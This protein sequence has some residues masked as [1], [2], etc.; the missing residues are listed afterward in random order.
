MSD[1]RPDRRLRDSADIV[2]SASVQAESLHFTAVPWSEVTFH[3]EPGEESASG[4]RREGLPDHVTEGET[5]RAIRIDYA[6]ASKLTSAREPG[7]RRHDG[8]GN[9]NVRRGDP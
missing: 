8:M 3:G 7:E 2:F 1:R 6:I 5:Y 4:S 9:R